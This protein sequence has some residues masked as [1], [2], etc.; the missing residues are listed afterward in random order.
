MFERCYSPCPIC[1]PS[2]ASLLTGKPVPSHGVYKLHDILP[3]DEVLLP[4]RLQALGYETSLIGK[5]HVSG[6]WH[7]AEHRHPNDGF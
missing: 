4:H 2:R 6:L 3:D 1:T 5:L 7:E